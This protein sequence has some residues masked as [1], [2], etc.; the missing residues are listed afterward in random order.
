MDAHLVEAERLLEL[1]V[2]GD[3]N[4]LQDDVLGTAL[5]EDL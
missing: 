5:S 3:G 2:S 4:G 1:E